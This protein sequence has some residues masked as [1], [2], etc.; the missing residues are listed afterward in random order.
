MKYFNLS[1]FAIFALGLCLFASSQGRE[2][3][4]GALTGLAFMSLGLMIKIIHLI[5]KKIKVKFKK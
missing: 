3:F 1:L 2:E 5:L 4:I